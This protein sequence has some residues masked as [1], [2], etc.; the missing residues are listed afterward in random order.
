[1]KLKDESNLN[2]GVGN[3]IVEEEKTDDGMR[4]REASSK[5]RRNG[6]SLD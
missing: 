6:K 3:L 2:E 1:M 4:M 5:S